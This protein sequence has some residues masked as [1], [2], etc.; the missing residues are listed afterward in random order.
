MQS[1]QYKSPVAGQHLPGDEGRSLIR[2]EADG[3]GDVLRCA[4]PPQRRLLHQ[5]RHDLLG[6]RGEHIRLDNAR[7]HAV[8]P[9]ARGGKL[10]RQ[11]PGQ[12]DHRALGGGIRHLAAGTPQPPDG[13]DVHDAALVLP[14]HGG[15]HRLHRVV[16]AVHIDGEIPM[17]HLVGGV[18][19]QSLSRHAGVV[20]QQR[21][22][23]EFPLDPAH[24]LVHLRPIRHVRLHGD[25]AS[26]RRPY[27]L[28]QCGGAVLPLPV[29]DAHGVALRRQ[30]ARHCPPDTAGGAGH[31][32]DF[33]HGIIPFSQI[34]PVSIANFRGKGKKSVDKPGLIR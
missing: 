25:G 27:L 14:Q 8:H 32:R 21:Y 15:Q 26:A 2:E 20:H 10:R 18:L 28:H 5:L 19:K 12:R 3:G 1:L 23:A 11:R 7:S 6:Q 22:L 17:P 29:V 4:Q 9:Y 30:T 16:R 33:L 24:H 13:R 34:L 31:Q